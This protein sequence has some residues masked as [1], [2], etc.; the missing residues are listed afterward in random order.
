M[1]DNER[2]LDAVRATLRSEAAVDFQNHP[3]EF[4]L[5]GDTLT[6]TGELPSVPA[7]KLALERA[8]ALPGIEGIVDRL[9]VTPAQTMGDGAIR[10]EVRKA[11]LQEPAFSAFCLRETRGGQTELVQELA[12]RN[13]TIEY[14]VVDGVVTLNGEV[15]GLGHKRLAGVLAWWIPGSRDVVN[16][17]AENPPEQDNDDEVS[18]GVR[19]ALEKDVFVNS[20]QIRVSTRDYVVTLEGQVATE[21][22]KGM[23]ERDAW[24]VFGV[25]KVLNKLSVR[26]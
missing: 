17:I 9:R 3:L 19:T 23:A 18:D 2:I 8:A 26:P 16:G 25:D 10:D 12:E 14:E 21:A 11:F 24:Y 6:M 4:R 5:E 22:E 1:S 7:K 20:G 15:P 13:G